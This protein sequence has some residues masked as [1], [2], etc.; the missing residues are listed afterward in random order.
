M[1]LFLWNRLGGGFRSMDA[2]REPL[3]ILVHS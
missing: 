1:R 2:T 3:Q